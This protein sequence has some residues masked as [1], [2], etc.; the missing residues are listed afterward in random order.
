MSAHNRLITLA[1]AGLVAGALGVYAEEMEETPKQTIDKSYAILE[2]ATTRLQAHPGLAKKDL[3]AIQA[4]LKKKEEQQKRLRQ[5]VVRLQRDT[6]KL[7]QRYA[8]N[9]EARQEIQDSYGK[10][11][12]ASKEELVI[13]GKGINRLQG[14]LA[15][16][17]AKVA[18][19][20]VYTEDETPD[21]DWDK[22]YQ[23][24]AI[25][26]FLTAK[27]LISDR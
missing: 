26:R 5:T 14:R 15:R 17:H 27:D 12:A 8:N 3:L 23:E 2:Q 21:T 20:S 22:E 13:L 18:L 24:L 16:Q 25:Q 9:P 11:I 19:D 6:H 7:R 10:R 1:L 4:G